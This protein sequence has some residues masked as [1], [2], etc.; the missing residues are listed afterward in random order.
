MKIPTIVCEIAEGVKDALPVA[1]QELPELLTRL[2]KL[3][4]EA[5]RLRLVRY[6]RKSKK[7]VS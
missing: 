3:I 4:D 7:R 2:R 1:R 6:I 5:I